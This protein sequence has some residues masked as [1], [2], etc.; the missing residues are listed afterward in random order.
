MPRRPSANPPAY[1][2]HKQSGQAVVDLPDGQGARH[3]VTLGKHDSPESR[4][5]YDRVISEWLLAGRRWP[6]RPAEDNVCAVN[7][8]T[9]AEVILAYWQHVETYYR[10]PDSTPTSEAH[11]IK[12]ALRPLRRLYGHT[13]ADDF[14]SLALEAVRGEMIREGHCRNRINRDLPRLK[15]LFKW[16]AS[17]KLVPLTVSQS[18]ATVEGYLFT[19]RG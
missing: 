15:R 14:D 2:L 18:L 12:L 16:A 19:G 8:L 17:R 9:V 6:P 10:S 3:T 1:R 5:E 11:N 7:D 13:R 4:A